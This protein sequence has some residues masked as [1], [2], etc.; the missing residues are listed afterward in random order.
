MVGG[1]YWLRCHSCVSSPG[2]APERLISVL[3]DLLILTKN[4]VFLCTCPWRWLFSLSVPLV[5]FFKAH[6]YR[7]V[8]LTSPSCISENPIS[9]YQAPFPYNLCI[10]IWPFI[11][12]T[13]SAGFAACW[14]RAVSVLHV[15][16]P[17]FCKWAFCPRG[18]LTEPILPAASLALGL[19]C[20]APELLEAPHPQR[21]SLALVSCKRSVS[22]DSSADIAQSSPRSWRRLVQLWVASCA[23]YRACGSATRAWPLSSACRQNPQASLCGGQRAANRAVDT[24]SLLVWFSM[25][26]IFFL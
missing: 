16:C 26:D 21:V 15:H 17:A 18:A 6:Q 20:S 4:Q 23:T 9:L 13:P 11:F 19:T 1:L 24:A 5:V 14:P 7:A 12:T 8:V 2:L 22:G 10:Q 3:L 25:W